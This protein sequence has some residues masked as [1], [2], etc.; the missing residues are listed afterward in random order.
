MYKIPDLSYIIAIL[1]MIVGFVIALAG[2][3]LFVGIMQL[4][5]YSQVTDP[6]TQVFGPMIVGFLILAVGAVIIVA[7]NKLRLKLLGY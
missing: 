4:T 5:D 1:V 2:A 3:L 6:V 7:G